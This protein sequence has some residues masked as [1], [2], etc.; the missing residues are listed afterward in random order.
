MFAARIIVRHA[1]TTGLL[2]KPS[3]WFGGRKRLGRPEAVPAAKTKWLAGSRAKALTARIEGVD[4]AT[5]R[6]E[7]CTKN[8][9]RLTACD[10]WL[11][12]DRQ[13]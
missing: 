10:I 2:S 4:P 3:P 11:G 12:V 7:R 1:C 5:C 8:I 9:P 13:Q 6:Q